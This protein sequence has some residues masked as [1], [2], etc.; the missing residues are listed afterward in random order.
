M[1]LA[2]GEEI[3]DG[4]LSGM[5][6][7]TGGESTEERDLPKTCKDIAKL[8]DQMFGV[9]SQHDQDPSLVANRMIKEAMRLSGIANY[10]PHPSQTRAFLQQNDADEDGQIGMKDLEE[11]VSF[12]MNERNFPEQAREAVNRRR[13]AKPVFSG[14]QIGDEKARLRLQVY[15]QLDE[16]VLEQVLQ[17]CRK[18][19]ELFDV[20]AA[21]L[22]EYEALIPLLSQVYTL[23]NIQFRPN[24]QDAK[25]YIEIIDVDQDGVISWEEFE[26]FVL[27]IVANLHQNNN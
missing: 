21:G 15:E 8:F 18:R 6:F 24:S 17:E 5:T 16:Q 2:N 13:S 7:R 20:E 19:F 9:A 22:V 10:Q 12:F 27:K 11:R 23:F 25:K 3:T 1:N 26:L 14:H 4:E